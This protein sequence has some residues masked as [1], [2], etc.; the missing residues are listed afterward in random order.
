[1]EF[2][3]GKPITLDYDYV[4]KLYDKLLKLHGGTV[5]TKTGLIFTIDNSIHIVRLG[6]LLEDNKPQNTYIQEHPATEI[7]E[8]ES[9]HSGTSTLDEWKS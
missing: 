9:E 4:E 3:E 2:D 1:M 6:K 8:Y 7:E 5:E